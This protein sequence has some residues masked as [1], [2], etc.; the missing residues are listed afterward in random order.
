[1]KAIES[2]SASTTSAGSA[3]PK[4]AQPAGFA[5]IYSDSVTLPRPQRTTCSRRCEQNG[6][7]FVCWCAKKN[8]R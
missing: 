5:G 7:V 2:S 8:A 3:E 1:M 4:S 6:C